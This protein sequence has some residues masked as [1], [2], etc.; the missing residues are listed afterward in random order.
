MMLAWSA[1]GR[2]MQANGTDSANAGVD[3]TPFKSARQQ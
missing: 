1:P 3:K 2:M